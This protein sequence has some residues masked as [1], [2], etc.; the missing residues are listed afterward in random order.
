M[1][2]GQLHT[3]LFK[4]MVAGFCHCA[5]V[6]DER[7]ELV[8]WIY[9][10]VNDSFAEQTGMRDVVGKKVSELLPS[11]Q[12]EN[13]NLFARY[14]AVSRGG[15]PDKFESYLPALERWL[16][17]SVYSVERGTFSVV[18]NNI[19]ATKRL[20]ATLKDASD[21]IERAYEETLMGL[22]RALRFRHIETEQHTQH[23][24]DL[25]LNIARTFG[26]FGQELEYY[27]RG[28]MLHDIG[29]MFVSDYILGK[30]GA[31][32]AEETQLM[33]QHTTLAWD[34]LLPLS[35]ISPPILDIPYHHHERWD[36][37][38]YPLGLLGEQ[39]PISARIFAVADVYDAMTHDRSHRR[40]FSR[41]FVLKYIC[42][43]AST[44]F[45]PLCVDA[46]VTLFM[47]NFP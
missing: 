28:A 11:I 17:L 44:L 8:D 40:A 23:V 41:D 22:V 7:G 5:A 35:F 12:Q 27:R 31:L 2:N 30:E 32:N 21:R 38:G 9:L 1:N 34:F 16:Q 14:G 33:R 18:F 19:T 43:Q 39:T 45:D 26:I 10:V 29:Q 13:A 24:T 37:S 15:N 3:A 6:Y 46:F 36:G 42:N 4:N 20:A 25:F 47:G